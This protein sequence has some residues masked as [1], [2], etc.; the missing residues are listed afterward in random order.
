MGSARRGFCHVLTEFYIF[1]ASYILAR[2]YVDFHIK[3]G[4]LFKIIL[5]TAVMA[6]A[7]YYAKEPTYHLWGL[8]NKTFCC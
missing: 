6:A 3:F 2:R 4:R 1:V 7:L 8:Q 5:A